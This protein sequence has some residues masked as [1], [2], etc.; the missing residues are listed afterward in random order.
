MKR[1][2]QRQ[3]SQTVEPNKTK[4]ESDREKWKQNKNKWTQKTIKNSPRT[5]NG[6]QE[7]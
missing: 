4:K 5:A 2:K 6:M 1:K 7:S 3:K